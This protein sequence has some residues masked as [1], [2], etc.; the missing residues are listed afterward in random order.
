MTFNYSKLATLKPK[1]VESHQD[2][3]QA[4]SGKPPTPKTSAESHQE[5]EVESHQ[6][7]EEKKH[8]RGD[9]H[10]KNRIT[11]T[12]RYAPII[13]Q[14]IK[15]FCS[16]HKLQIQDFYELA[17]SYYMDAVESHLVESKQATMVA[18]L[19]AHDDLMIFKTHDDIIMLFKNLTGRK[20][21]ASDD[22]AAVPFNNVDRRL[23][24]I[25]MINTVIQARGRRINSFAYFIPEIQTMIDLHVDNQNLDAYL[26]RR[27]ELLAKY[28]GQ[29]KIKARE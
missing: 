16:V 20:W 5:T 26:R 29:E 14:R 24:E 12:T 13:H 15:D 3:E 23:I 6:E 21:T 17:A 1:T 11:V 28:R 19:Q 4:T 8:R 22:R 2:I 10:S 7:T 18:C 25:G 27:R 9:R